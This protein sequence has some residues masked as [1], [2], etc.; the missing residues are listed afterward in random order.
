MNSANIRWYTY[1][2]PHGTCQYSDEKPDVDDQPGTYSFLNFTLLHGFLS[3][4]ACQSQN[5]DHTEHPLGK[6]YFYVK[7]SLDDHFL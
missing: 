7:I 2:D 3:Q 1:P 4:S 5:S 6:L